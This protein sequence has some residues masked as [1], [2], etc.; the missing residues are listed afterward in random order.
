MR[1][2]EKL[3]SFIKRV[4]RCS[5]IVY[6]GNGASGIYTKKNRR[7][8]KM[9][10]KQ[11]GAG[12]LRLVV[13]QKKIGIF[14]NR[15]EELFWQTDA[16]FQGY[17]A[18]K[19]V[20]GIYYWYALDNNWYSSTELVTNNSVKKRLFSAGE[21]ISIKDSNDK[22][23]IMVAQWTNKENGQAMQMGYPIFRHKLMAHALGAY[24]GKTYTNTREA[25]ESAYANGYRYF[26][27]DVALT[28]D[29]RMVLS[30]GWNEKAC[31]MTGMQ[32][33]EAFKHMTWQLFMQQDIDGLHVMDISDLKAFMKEYPETYFEIDLHRS[34]AREKIKVLLQ[35]FEGEEEL[36]D[37]LLIQAESRKIFKEI[38]AT[39]HFYN[40]Q[41]I[42]GE[43]WLEKLEEAIAFALDHGI[44]TIAM[45]QVL[46]DEKTVAILHEAGLNVM[47]YTIK[48]DVKR[49]KEL[50]AMGVNTICTDEVKPIDL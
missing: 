28:E 22:N 6:V 8:K 26:E 29:R 38:D 11:Q 18:A 36:L 27:V 12:M 17:F 42:L 15:A 45:R 39:H 13:Y 7:Y 10:F 40:C 41:L 3:K 25:L 24:Q 31:A 4:L 47:A 23:I 1:I 34:D 50:L 14:K 21:K 16:D 2:M 9:Q 43:K 35:A 30:H 20:E 32:Y 46:F 5:L 19:K 33:Q 37:R 48:N 49:T 44:E